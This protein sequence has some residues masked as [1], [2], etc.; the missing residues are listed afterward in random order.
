MRKSLFYVFLAATA[1]T[2]NT[3]GTARA[4]TGY[5]PSGQRVEYTCGVGSPGTVNYGMG[6]STTKCMGSFSAA[7]FGCQNN[8]NGSWGRY[9]NT[10]TQ[11]ID[12]CANCPDGAECD[13]DDDVFRCKGGYYRKKLYFS[14][15]GTDGTCIQCPKRTVYVCPD[16]HH[17]NPSCSGGKQVEIAA[18]DTV[19]GTEE[20]T[21]DDYD[22]GIVKSAS[23]YGDSP[24]GPFWNDIYDCALLTGDWFDDE[25][26]GRGKIRNGGIC[27]W[28]D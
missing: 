13:A 28:K 27:R 14:F 17:D 7:W 4:N 6:D 24:D 23:S 3:S 5:L 19:Q 16:G 10:T 9:Y 18:Q 2:A 1:I 12:G 21:W 15:S 26:I 8:T 22:D 20:F 11:T 25:G